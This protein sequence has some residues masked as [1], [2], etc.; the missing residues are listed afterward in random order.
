ME[1]KMKKILSLVYSLK[2]KNILFLTRGSIFIFFSNGHIHNVVSTLLSVVQIY[3]ENDNV[4]STLS[5]VVQINVEIDNVD[6]TLFNVLD[7][8]VYQIARPK[9]NDKFLVDI[10]GYTG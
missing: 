10:K 2:L 5:N 4:V 8:T 3:V 9:N 1:G 7:G 6:S